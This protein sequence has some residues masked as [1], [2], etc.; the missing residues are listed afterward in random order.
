MTAAARAARGSHR[1]VATG[2]TTWDEPG[3]NATIGAGM[4]YPPTEVAKPE[5]RDFAI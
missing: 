2:F 5:Y 1:E 3:T 4:L